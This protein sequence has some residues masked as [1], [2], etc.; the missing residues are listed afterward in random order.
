MSTPHCTNGPEKLR[1]TPRH[2]KEQLPLIG[3]IDV[4][5]SPSC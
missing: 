1:S 2:T 5:D 4:D 3:C